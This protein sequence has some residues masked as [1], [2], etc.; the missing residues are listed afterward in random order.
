MQLEPQAQNRKKAPFGRFTLLA[1]IIIAA[2]YVKGDFSTAPESQPKPKAALTDED[3]YGPIPGS[4]FILQNAP[5]LQLNDEQYRKVKRIIAE[6][7]KT[8]PLLEKKIKVASKELNDQLNKALESGKPSDTNQNKLPELLKD[9][10]AAKARLW[11][12]STSTLTSQQLKVLNELRM[13]QAQKKLEDLNIQAPS[14]P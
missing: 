2:L 1:L 5:E 4:A 8:L 3:K 7:Q 13:K 12:Q 10:Q 11:K 9:Y 6:E 14:S